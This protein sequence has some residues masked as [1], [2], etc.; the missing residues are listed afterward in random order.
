[1]TPRHKGRKMGKKNHP[2]NGRGQKNKLRAAP[3]KVV[4]APSRHRTA[5]KR[6][7][8]S[9]NGPP[10]PRGSPRKLWAVPL[11]IQQKTVAEE[12]PP[13][14]AGE[15]EMTAEP[16]DYR[17]FNDWNAGRKIE[18]ILELIVSLKSCHAALNDRLAQARMEFAALKQYPPP[19]L[20]G[21]GPGAFGKQSYGWER[22]LTR[23]QWRPT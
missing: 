1:M 10:V 15:E 17:H 22:K 21:A 16:H 18:H 14:F 11:P 13:C 12:L 2:A 5:S 8:K 9:P 19:T 20:I 4:S 23:R 6:N 3:I 7:L